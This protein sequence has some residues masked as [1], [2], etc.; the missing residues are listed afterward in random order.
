M[1][2]KNQLRRYEAEVI[3]NAIESGKRWCRRGR[4]GYALD[5]KE[6]RFRVVTLDEEKEMAYALDNR[7]Q[8]IEWLCGLDLTTRGYSNSWS[9]LRL[10]FGFESL[11]EWFDRKDR[12]SQKDG[13]PIEDAWRLR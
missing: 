8:F 11:D 7:E 10:D 9:F 1:N 13:S 4:A 3:A 12:E 5:F 2:K 6:G